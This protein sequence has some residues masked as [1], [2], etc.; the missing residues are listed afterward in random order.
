MAETLA[1]ETIAEGVEDVEQAEHLQA[2]GSEYVQ[3]YLFS[4]PLPAGE[5]T[6]YLRGRDHAPGVVHR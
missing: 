4:R 2:L 6:E 1:L 3:G 5:A